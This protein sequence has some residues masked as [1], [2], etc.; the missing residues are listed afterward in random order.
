MS[1]R[2]TEMAAT[3]TSSV[4]T[5][6]VRFWRTAGGHPNDRDGRKAVRGGPKPVSQ[7]SVSAWQKRPYSTLDTVS[8]RRPKTDAT[9][10]VVLDG[11]LD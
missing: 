5:G 3:T 8:Y 10:M 1:D 7:L 9:D 6:D 11:L 4:V 2:M